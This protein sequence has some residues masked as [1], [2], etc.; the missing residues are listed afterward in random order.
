MTQARQFLG[1]SAWSV[2]SLGVSQAI[3]LAVL[4]YMARYLE[5]HEFGVVAISVLALELTRD[6]MSAGLPDYLVRE[7]VWHEDIASSAF[8]FQ[9]LAGMGLGLAMLGAGALVSTD[10]DV[11]GLSHRSG[12]LGVPCPL[13]A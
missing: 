5:A 1:S 8:T 4:A 7:K 12:W 2:G 13:A 3:G 9:L 6:L 10:G 11:G